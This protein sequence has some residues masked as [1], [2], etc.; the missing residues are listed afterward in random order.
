[1]NELLENAEEFFA[2][3]EDNL[4]KK[5]YNAS[6]SDYF[7]SISN[8]CDFLIYKT[9]KLLPKNHNERFDLLKKYF[10][11]IYSIILTLF[12]KYRESYNLRLNE[13]DALTLRGYT[14]E[15]RDYT[16]GKK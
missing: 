9:M 10:P 1:M 2:S 8:Y 7:K 13:K 6:V 11:D 12:Q 15:I 14:H 5:R 4:K 3:A 16:K